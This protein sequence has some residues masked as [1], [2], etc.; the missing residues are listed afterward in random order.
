M[1]RILICG[2]VL[3]LAFGA[4]ALP[5]AV[6]APAVQ[7]TGE[8]FYLVPNP[9]GSPPVTDGPPVLGARGTIHRTENGVAINIHTVDLDPNHVYTV[10]VIEVN[11]G[12]PRCI[13]VQLA[14]HIIGKSGVGNFSGF[15]GLNSDAAKAV[16]DPFGG[17]F[18]CIIADHG[19]VD[20][21]N[22]PGAIMTPV[23]P[24]APDGT[25]NWEQVVIF[26]P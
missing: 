19:E 18:H 23:P 15:L 21:S 26:S 6:A 10:W 2:I 20:P 24:I 5:T 9:G 8:A 7:G 16:Q 25:L 12:E 13:P 17:D 1:K 14:G 22:L 11:C 4:V 3:A